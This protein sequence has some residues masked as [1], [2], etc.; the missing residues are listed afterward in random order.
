MAMSRPM[1]LEKLQGYLDRSIP[2]KDI[3]EWALLTAVS[4]E[5]DAIS[6]SDPLIAKTVYALTEISNADS[7]H[8][9]GETLEYC[10]RCLL[11]ELEFTPGVNRAPDPVRT[12]TPAPSWDEKEA[13]RQAEECRKAELR[14]K[15]Y[16]HRLYLLGKIYVILFAVCC[17]A[18]HLLVVFFPQ[19]LP[20]SGAKAMT[21]VE[22]FRESLTPLVYSVLL[23]LPPC[24]QVRGVFFYILAPIFFLGMVSYWYLSVFAIV[25]KMELNAMFLLVILP[26]TAF[27]ST[28]AFV[29]L[30]AERRRYRS[31]QAQR[32]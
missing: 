5:F 20:S 1:V 8:H 24:L 15:L 23:L 27:P 11:G 10:R 32:S 17:L 7:R 26:F 22:A 13:L 16:R 6:G 4:K 14:R 30:L 3:Y 28:V 18:V 9:V 31:R 2:E 12:G 21:R 19:L 29:M 25:L